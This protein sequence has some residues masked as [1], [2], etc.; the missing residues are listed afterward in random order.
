M[1][2][3]LSPALTWLLIVVLCLLVAL[4]IWSAMQDRPE[5]W[6]PPE[7]T[8]EN[9]RES[10]RIVPNPYFRADRPLYDWQVD[11]RDDPKKQYDQ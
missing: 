11:E 4:L 2:L 9:E 8:W 1:M 3:T 6:A 10:I 7:P 5:R